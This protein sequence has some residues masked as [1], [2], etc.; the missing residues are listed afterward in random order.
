MILSASREAY[1]ICVSWH[2]GLAEMDLRMIDSD[3]WNSK[4]KLETRKSDKFEYAPVLNFISGSSQD[5]F[6]LLCYTPIRLKHC[7]GPGY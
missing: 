3:L 6:A 4:T 2:C 7:I 5:H 1:C